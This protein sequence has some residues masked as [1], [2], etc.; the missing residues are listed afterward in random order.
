MVEY[1]FNFEI[2][3]NL[4][5]FQ[6]ALD[7]II[8]KRYDHSDNHVTDSIK[9]NVKYAPKSKLLEDL[10]GQPDTV[11]FPICAITVGGY[12]RDNERIK[13]KNEVISYKTET[14]ESINLQAIPWNIN[15]TMHILAKYQE[16][17]DQII[18]NFGVLANPYIVFSWRE[19]KSGRDVRSEVL[20]DGNVN[21]VYPTHGGDVQ[22]NMPWRY[23]ANANFTIKTHLYRT[24]VENTKP[25]CKIN[26]DVIPTNKFFCNYESLSAYTKDNQKD[27]FELYG[28]PNLRYVYDYYFKVGDTPNIRITGEGFNGIYGL[29]LSGS[30]PDMYPMTTYYPVSGSNESFNG[31]AIDEFNIPNPQELTFNMPA[32]S[33]FGFC[34]IIAVNS[35][36]W[37]KLTEDANRCNRVL[38]PYPVAL[39]AHYSWCVQQYPYLNGLIISN[40]LNDNLEISCEDDIIVVENDVIDRDAI[41]EKIKELMELG[42][43]SAGEL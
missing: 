15:V 38:N 33:A 25:I 26:L 11:K 42:G 1:N 9:V 13:N 31:Y 22:A 8:I 37:S 10:R 18:G 7:D 29:F 24:S 36:G 32:P 34:D 28:M 6:S 30:N 4:A 23:E 35:C 3:S 14:G 39:P 2:A 21:I 20:W 41:L 27:S 16:D 17:I 5:F 43:I 12:G 19:P 40:N